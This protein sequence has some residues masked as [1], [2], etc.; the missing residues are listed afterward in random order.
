MLKLAAISLSNATGTNSVVLKTNAATASATTR[1]QAVFL[2]TCVI[3]FACA[4]VDISKNPSPNQKL[5]GIEATL[6]DLS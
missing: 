3:V 1:I 4:F 2:E 5:I 6:L